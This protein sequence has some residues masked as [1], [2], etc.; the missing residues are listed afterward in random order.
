MPEKELTMEPLS[1]KDTVRISGDV[2]FREIDGEGVLLNLGTG[3]YFGLNDVGTRIWNLLQQDGSLR[4][5]FHS[6]QKQYDVTPDRL[7]QDLLQL[8]SQMLEKGLV[9][10]HLPTPV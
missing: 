1:L 2:V 4:K 8:V 7:E 10:E 3:I 6:L 9:L 5:V